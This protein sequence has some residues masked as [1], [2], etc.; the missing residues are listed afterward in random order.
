MRFPTPA[1]TTSSA[2]DTSEEVLI[3][4]SIA[5]RNSTFGALKTYIREYRRKTGETLTNAAAV[6]M[7]LRAHFA[8]HIHRE[9][10]GTM[11]R[12]SRP[13]AEAQLRS[14]PVE[15]IEDTATP[16]TAALAVTQRSQPSVIA[17]RLNTGK[18]RPWV[19]SSGAGQQLALNWGEPGEDT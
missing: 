17:M 14:L 13:A 4:R 6:D 16:V 12:M 8:Y 15:E 18:S 5:F 1:T 10:V 3:N 2:P 19:R 11:L 7:I 9:A